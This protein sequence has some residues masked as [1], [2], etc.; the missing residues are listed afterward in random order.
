MP[1]QIVRKADGVEIPATL[2]DTVA[3]KAFLKRL[4][5]TVSGTRSA[6]DYCCR[7]ACGVFDPPKRSPAGKTGI[8]AC[9]SE[10][11]EWRSLA[12]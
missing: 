12:C 8:S 10:G 1:S 3:A 7:T 4:P 6:V 5:F 2:N 9:P 11:N